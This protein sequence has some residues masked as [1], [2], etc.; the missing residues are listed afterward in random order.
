MILLSS[1]LM[2]KS[3]LD[4]INNFFHMKPDE[5]KLISKL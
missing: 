2:Y 1:R 5:D 4:K 3:N